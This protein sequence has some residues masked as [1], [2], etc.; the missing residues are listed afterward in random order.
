MSA[1]LCVYAQPQLSADNIEEVLAAMTLQEKATL[2]VGGS[3]AAIMEGVTTGYAWQVPGA[4]GSTRPI[5][6]LGIPVTV[7]A[8]GPAGLRISPTRKGTDKT[9]Y[10]TGFPSGTLLASSWDTELLEEIGKALGNEVLE[11]GV[12]V[13]LAPGMNIHRNPLCGRNF[14]YYSEDP[15]LAGKIGAAYVRGVQSNGVGVSAKHFAANNQEAGR[16]WNDAR[17]DERTLREIYLKAF[18]IMVKE[19]KPWTIMSS[20]NKINGEF[21]Q[22]RKDLLTTLLREEWGF[23]G[24]VMTDWGKKSGTHKAVWA[25]ND[26][27]EPGYDEE[28]T[29]ILDAVQNGSLDV[30]DIDRNVRNILRYIVKTPSFHKYAFSNNPDLEAHNALSRRAAAE[31]SILLRNEDNAL[32]L[33]AGEKVALYGITALDFV[34]SGTGSGTTGRNKIVDLRQGMEEAGFK[35]DGK[36]LKYYEAQLAVDK[37]R[38]QMLPEGNRGR[39]WTKAPELAI[40]QDAIADQ[41]EKNDVAVVILGRSAGEARDRNYI[42]DFELSE[43]ERQLLQNV[44]NAFHAQGKKMIVVL[45]ICGVIETASWKDMADAILLPWA[46]GQEGGRVITDVLTGKV[47][48]SGKLPMTFPVNYYDDPSSLNFPSETEGFIQS[49]KGAFRKDIEY[50]EYAEGIYVGYR[51]YTTAGAEVSY[52]FGYGLSYTTFAYSKPS[53]K[54][55]KDGFEARITVSNTGSVPG[56]ESVQLYVSAPAGGLEKPARELKGFAKTRELQPGESQTLTIKVSKYDLASFNEEVSEWQAAAG[57]YNISFGASVNDIRATGSYKLSKKAVWKTHKLFAHTHPE[58]LDKK[59]TVEAGKKEA[60]FSTVIRPLEGEYWWGAVIEKGYVQPYVNFDSNDQRLPWQE[61][62]TGVRNSTL[63]KG[64]PYDLGIHGS[65]GFTVPLLLSSKGRYVW[66]D[67]PFAFEFKE[68]VLYLESKYEKIEAEQAG[69]TLRDAYMAACSEHFPFDGREPAELMFTKPQFNNWIETVVLGINQ[70]NAEKFVDALHESGFPCGVVMI[71]GGWQ[72][73]HGCR[74]FNPDTFPEPTR[75]FDKIHD[76]GYKGVLWCAYFLTPDSR[77]EYVSYRPGG[78]N[79]L[80]RRRDNPREAALVWWWS[81]ISVTMDLTA[82]AVRQ[83]FVDELKAMAERFH[84]DGFK[85]DGGDPEYFRGNALFSEPWMEPADFAHAYNL[86]GLDFPY[87]EY[88]AGF[89]A[90][91]LPLVLRLHDVGHSWEELSTIIPNMTLAG[92]SGQPYVFADMIGGGLSSCFYPGKTFSHKLFIRS[93]QIQ[94]LTPMMQFS[95]APWR[96]LTKEECDICRHFADLHVEFGPYIM[97]QV[98]LASSTGEPIMRSMEY[99]FPGCGYERVDGQFMLGPKYLVA[100][101]T[102][103]DDCKTVYLPAGRWRDDQGKTWRG[104]KVLELKD[105]PLER[106]PYYEKIG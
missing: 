46:P 82:P 1:A 29:R 91:G 47:N 53:V 78:Q 66:S 10:T 30:A 88:R 23:D 94:A 36:I 63:G 100:P 48:P 81:G 93:C 19:S 99:E 87:N 32:P 65:K 79:I 50:T 35:L 42:K 77:P 24:I 92:L 25:G 86:A 101:V 84:F 69:K 105:V 2:L 57:T 62:E 49:Q 15:F 5:E 13:L 7:L 71:D 31:S 96:V 85:F 56:R 11:Y 106:L 60:K 70:E 26:L 22:Q 9:F 43:N 6:R 64:E 17:I 38:K 12:D 40:P 18:E 55:T 44:S 37:A 20:Y 76:Y 28:I 41:A 14:E 34:V 16:V 80:V 27:M 51:H 72:R 68:G 97:E 52:P 90:G 102:T 89:K 58:E 54:S 45:D 103:E 3:R 67:R 21:T 74:D 8:D 4:C 61:I 75:L 39:W 83:K 95:A 73:Y 104:P 59:P 98:H 33:K